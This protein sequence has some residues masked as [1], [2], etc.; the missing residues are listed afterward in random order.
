MVPRVSALNADYLASVLSDS[1]DVM[2][3][4]G[5][6][7]AHPLFAELG[8]SASSLR[9]SAYVYNTIADVRRFGEAL[10]AV[11]GRFGS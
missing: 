5:L 2:V 11:L 10:D 7:C 3:R 6:H 8:E 9:A 4:S 1:F